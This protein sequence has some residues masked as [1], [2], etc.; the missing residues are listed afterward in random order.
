MR[1]AININ[2][3][4]FHIDGVKTHA[5]NVWITEHNEIYISL[6]HPKGG[7]LNVLAREI[8][9]YCDATHDEMMFNNPEN[10]SPIDIDQKILSMG[11][12][13]NRNKRV[14]V[15]RGYSTERIPMKEWKL[16]Y[17]K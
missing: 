6:K 11:Y 10:L 7:E 15:L 3:R 16:K 8:H 9:N 4:E 12:G 2:D 5:T 14:E 13:K 1:D 17:T